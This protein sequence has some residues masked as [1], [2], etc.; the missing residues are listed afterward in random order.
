M[1]DEL[2]DLSKEKTMVSASEHSLKCSSLTTK[3]SFGS[4]NHLLWVI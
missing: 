4:P 3:M 2:L 1:E